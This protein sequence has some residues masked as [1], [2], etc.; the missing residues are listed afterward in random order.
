MKVRWILLVALLLHTN[1]AVQFNK[2]EVI[3]GFLQAIKK[4]PKTGFMDAMSGT[5]DLT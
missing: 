4:F 5:I 2:E 1:R 3:A